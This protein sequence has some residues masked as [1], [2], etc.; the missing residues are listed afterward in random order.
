MVSFLKL[1][2]DIGSRDVP[3]IANEAPDLLLSLLTPY[4]TPSPPGTFC[5]LV[6]KYAPRY[7]LA[8]TL[9]NEDA[10]AGR[11]V[12]GWDVA[13]MISRRSF[14]NSLHSEMN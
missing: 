1:Y 10:A 2:N 3:C 14:I 4:G 9:L 13:G 5:H 12:V 6:A 11:A 7:R 8:F